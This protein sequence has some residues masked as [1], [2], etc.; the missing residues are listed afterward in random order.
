MRL[1]TVYARFYKSFNFDH[2]RKAS[3][4]GKSKAEWEIFRGGW[5]PYVEVDVDFR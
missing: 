2:L 1:S 5:Y 3:Q 4:S